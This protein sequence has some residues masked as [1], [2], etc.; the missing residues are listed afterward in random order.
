MSVTSGNYSA[1][2]VGS[3]GVTSLGRTKTRVGP[4]T[5]AITAGKG[6]TELSVKMVGP[7]AERMSGIWGEK[8]E[9]G[10][11]GRGEGRE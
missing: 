11:R 6:P 1:P 2:L 4:G 5:V 9:A 8:R 10:E 3:A 7:G